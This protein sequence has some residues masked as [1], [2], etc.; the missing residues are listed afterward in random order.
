[1]FAEIT[2]L[3]LHTDLIHTDPPVENTVAGNQDRVVRDDT[4]WIRNQLG[5]ILEANLSLNEDLNEMKTTFKAGLEGM[6]LAHD[7][8]RKQMEMLTLDTAHL[9]NSSLKIED[10]LLKINDGQMNLSSRC[11]NLETRITSSSNLNLTAPSLE[12][13]SQA[14]PACPVRTMTPCDRCGFKT[15]SEYQLKRHQEVR[16]YAKKKLLYVGDDI[17]QNVDHRHLEKEAKAFIK[18]LKAYSAANVEL[19]DILSSTP[20]H[21]EQNYKDVVLNE[22]LNDEYS[23]LVLGSCTEDLSNL[24]TCED[25]S[26]KLDELEDIVLNSA[27]AMFSL[28]ETALSSFPKLKKVVLMMMPPQV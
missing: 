28:A 5:N 2:D 20:Q 4:T 22:L 18:P 19:N 10:V 17:I 24:K 7:T 14:P 8:L 6:A 3:K 25:P 23:Y 21:P 16:H 9:R 15:Y 13:Q 12:G 11:E 26:E 27:K 1:M